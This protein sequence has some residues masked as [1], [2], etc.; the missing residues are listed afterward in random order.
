MLSQGAQV[1]TASK[2]V[3]RDQY[4]NIVAVVTLSPGMVYMCCILEWKRSTIQAT[5]IT[6]FKAERLEF[7]SPHR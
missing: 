2:L 7:V 3:N 4:F 5:Q 1:N 6:V